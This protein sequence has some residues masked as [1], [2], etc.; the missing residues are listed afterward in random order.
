MFKNLIGSNIHNFDNLD[1]HSNQ[2]FPLI[3]IA[4][5]WRGAGLLI[6]IHIYVYTYI[7]FNSVAWVTLR[8]H[9][10]SPQIPRC[11]QDFSGHPF[12][13]RLDV[14]RSFEC[15]QYGGTRARHLNDEIIY[16]SD[17]LSEQ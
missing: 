2:R 15:M 1:I 3:F 16:L 14:S 4:R 17:I 9:R 8:A 5:L 11:P 12:R 13:T 10:G 7:N 6:F